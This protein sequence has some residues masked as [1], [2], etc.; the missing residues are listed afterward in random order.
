[1]K[2]QLN[3]LQPKVCVIR[4]QINPQVLYLNTSYP[5]ID[6]PITQIPDY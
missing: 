6:V 5:R 1:M 3:Q 4:N 2:F